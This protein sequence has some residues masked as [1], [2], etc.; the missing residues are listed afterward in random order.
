[1]TS[2][3]LKGFADA[4]MISLVIRNLLTNAVKFS[5]KGGGITLNSKINGDMIE[6]SI[7]DAGSGMSYEMQQ[8]VFNPN[9]V[10][11]QTGTAMEKGSGLGLLLCKEFVE[12]NGGKIWVESKEGRGSTFTFSLKLAR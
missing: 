2:P 10:L 8:K 9:A 12:E 3:N 4:N 7:T 6:F 11:G 5:P 1:M